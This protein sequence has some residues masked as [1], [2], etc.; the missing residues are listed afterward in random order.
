MFLKRLKTS[1]RLLYLRRNPNFQLYRPR[2]PIDLTSEAPRIIV[3]ATRLL[4]CKTQLGY[5]F[6]GGI[7]FACVCSRWF[8]WVLNYMKSSSRLLFPRRHLR[9]A[10]FIRCNTIEVLW[11]PRAVIIGC[12]A[13]SRQQNSTRLRFPRR[14]LV[15]MGHPQLGYFFHRRHANTE[16]EMLY[17]LGDFHHI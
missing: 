4:H 2:Y 7:W 8:I 13:N 3:G 14:Y 11:E 6:L 16:T 10:I 17:T 12:Y 5:F 1:T 15:F 9:F